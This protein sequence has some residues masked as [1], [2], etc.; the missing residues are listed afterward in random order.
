MAVVK[1]LPR[2]A[3][4][5]Q[6]R[7]QSMEARLDYDENPDKTREGKLVSSYMCSPETAAA[8]FEAAKAVYEA[9]T[10][11]SQPKDRD[12]TMYR[13]MQSFKLGEI[14]P[15]DANRIGYEL[16]MEFTKGQHQFVV[17]T[18]EDKAHIHN[19][20]E[21]NST[22]LDC[23]GKFKN[24]KNSVQVLR[25]INDRICL[26]H[27]LS[28]PEP[29]RERALSQ[30]EKGAVQHGRSFKERLRHTID[31][32]LP[33]CGDLEEFLDRMRE[34]GYEVKQRGKSLEFRA[35]GQER[36]T[37]SFRLGEQYTEEALR[38]R[39]AGQYKTPGREQLQTE[40]RESAERHGKAAPYGTGNFQDAGS[41][42]DAENSYQGE[43]HQSMSGGGHFENRNQGESGWKPKQGSKSA[44]LAGERRAKSQKT[45]RKVN[46]LV[47]IQAK[48][49]AGKGKGYERWARV[50]NLK[51]AS[52]T[53]NF[54]TERGVADYEE[55]E[56][57]TEAAG[58]RF[59]FLSA[60]IKQLEGQMAEKAQMK[61]HIINYAKTRDV[62]AAYKKSRYRDS[63]RNQHLEEIRKHE[64]AKAA[65][66]A[67][68][69]KAIPKVA[70]LSKDYEALLAEKK[71][72]YVEY[73]AARQEMIEYQTAKRNVD[74]ILGMD[75]DIREKQRDRNQAEH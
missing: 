16:A 33:G 3:A 62:Y 67:L 69:G 1:L 17:Y 75:E 53:I 9:T 6:G 29:K 48:L 15:E 35:P 11:R 32:Q 54:L 40:D 10:G 5:G 12:V 49:Q 30:G 52:K 38:E 28:I 57:R 61:M 64:A 66:D 2:K 50:F 20:I 37:R 51:E 21:I 27:G 23:D 8:E 42:R 47:D 19:H 25:R 18:H 26:A 58:Q 4:P 70:D 22:N 41:A 36:F 34:N 74:M 60:C 72:C 55:L 63:F 46:L 73:K 31:S 44:S 13:L 14:T 7:R 45:D 24:V 68:G 39:I 43:R 56:V 71:Q 59:D 65:F